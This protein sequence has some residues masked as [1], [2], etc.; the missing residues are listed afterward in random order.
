MRKIKRLSAFIITLSLIL[1]VVILP[2]GVSASAA[3]SGNY[4]YSISG[5]GAIITDC[6]E[7]I[8][9]AVT[10]PTKLGGKPVVEIA[11][12]AFK[13]CDDMTSVKVPATVKTI[14]DSAFAYCWK[15]KKVTLSSGLTTIGSY[16]FCGN[17]YLTTI[18]I[19]AT[20]TSIGESAFWSCDVLPSITVPAKV[21]VIGMSAFGACPKLTAINVN[22]SNTVYSAA[23]G[24]LF[25][26]NK[27][28]LI[29]FP[30]GKTGT[31][32]IPSTVKTIA[33]NAFQ[34]SKLTGINIPTSVNEIGSY[35][36]YNSDKL[37][38]LK[39]PTSITE[40]PSNACF[41]CDILSSVTIPNTVIAIN[42]YAFDSCKSLKTIKIPASVQRIGSEYGS[43][44]TVFSV[45]K[46]LTSITVD[47]NNKN[48][49]SIS[50]VLY[51]KDKKT[52]HVCPEAKAGKFTVPNG[53]EN[54]DYSAFYNCS[55]LTSVILPNSLVAIYES[56]F[57][58]CN[59]LTSITIPG[60]VSHLATSAFR[61]NKIANINVNSNNASFASINGVL[62]SK[63]KKTLIFYPVGKTGA[64]TVPNGTTTIASSAFTANSSLTRIY[65]PTSITTIADYAFGSPNYNE[66]L[67]H[68]Y[69]NGKKSA[70]K[71]NVTI[72]TDN[73]GTNHN[74]RLTGAS[75]HDNTIK[76]VTP[77]MSSVSNLKTGVK[78][79][80]KKVSGAEGYV[81]Y[82]KLGT[83]AWK[84][85]TTVY[86]ASKV[87]Y[88][89]KSAKKGKTYR[90]TVQ[91]F[92]GAYKSKYN[93][94]GLKIK[95]K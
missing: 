39:F 22:A 70:W 38:S 66:K 28:E 7:S 49:C 93:T 62:F 68:Y 73:Y 3:T 31:Y 46:K 84:K 35:A 82:R 55:A 95:R 20:V 16:A 4:T 42:S 81:I 18:T 34:Y 17:D 89:D 14:G 53:V 13:W 36:F 5:N 75:F 23:S 10:I 52:L 6:K 83:G 41:S 58:Y 43:P 94:T 91:A 64:Y 45:T 74:K 61:Y 88:T 85:L 51:S 30:A 11:A 12:N 25:N 69:Y 63:D 65:F 50:G 44:Y 19:P 92:H 60:N 15:L 76:S 78:F 54:I 9:G 57:G 72:E 21:T 27:T 48:Y 33:E 71:S 40:I 59:K 29:A 79:N 26:K 87:T 2:T 80:W 37:K 24:V 8:K 1:S 67:I 32:T 56:A 47:A 86:G 90:Y 77:K